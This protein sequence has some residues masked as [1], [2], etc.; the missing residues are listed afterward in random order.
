MISVKTKQWGNSVGLIIPKDLVRELNIKPNEEIKVEISK[1]KTNVLKE[2]YG[3]IKF[4]KPARQLIKEARKRVVKTSEHTYSRQSAIN[5][6]LIYIKLV[7]GL[8]KGLG[9]KVT[10]NWL[11]L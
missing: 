4:S 11:I 8:T 10:G 6:W 2:L 9:K 1:K 3:S 7:P 5:G